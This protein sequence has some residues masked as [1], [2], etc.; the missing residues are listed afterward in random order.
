MTHWN[1]ID[2]G[3]EAGDASLE[4]LKD[5]KGMLHSA[6]HLFYRA[7]ILAAAER[8]GRGRGR[9]G[10]A[11]LRRAVHRF[12]GWARNCADNFR[13]RG[14]VLKAELA[15]TRAKPLYALSLY[16]EGAEA[17]ARY[18][19]TQIAALAHRNASGLLEM[20]G[21]TTQAAEQR[22][23]AAE[24]YRRWGSEPLANRWAASE[25]ML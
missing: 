5:S 13:A 21:D 6:E 25:S 3:L 4:H 16:A 23:L 18:E 20:R 10:R 8:E 9:R 11:E 19:Q 15:Q 24:W 22:R 1:E 17:A 7:M 12:E 2:A 14:L